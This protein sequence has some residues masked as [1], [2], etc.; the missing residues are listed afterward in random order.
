MTSFRFDVG[1]RGRKAARFITRVRNELQKAVVEERESSGLN[2]QKLATKLGVNR[3][4]IN[5]QLSGEAN[6]T[7]RSVAE[8]AWALDRDI[9]FSLSKPEQ[10]KEVNYF[11][12]AMSTGPA[13][14]VLVKGLNS[15]GTSAFSS[16]ASGESTTGRPAASVSVG[17]D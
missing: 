17:V 7:L 1:S 9:E 2:Q 6:L 14:P 15:S 12:G 5:R 3:S 16:V 11:T 13:R 8:L 4:V 10:T